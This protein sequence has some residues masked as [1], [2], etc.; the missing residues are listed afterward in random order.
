M[1]W[2]EGIVSSPRTVVSC[3]H[4]LVGCRIAQSQVSIL[5]GK[6]TFAAA[7]VVP[8]TGLECAPWDSNPDLRITSSMPGVYRDH[9]S[10]LTCGS[11]SALVHA[12]HPDDWSPRRYAPEYAPARRWAGARSGRGSGAPAAAPSAGSVRLPGVDIRVGRDP[13]APLCAPF[14]RRSGPIVSARSVLAAE[15]SLTAPRA[16]WHALRST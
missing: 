3:L 12:V 1:T 15:A 2:P 7:P 5:V 8:P 14:D 16:P 6:A 10:A 4:R 9:C 13:E 11:G